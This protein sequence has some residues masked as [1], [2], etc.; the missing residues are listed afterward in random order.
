MN[1]SRDSAFS[2]LQS[3]IALGDLR[4]KGSSSTVV[5]IHKGGC[6]APT[7]LLFSSDGRKDNN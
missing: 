3:S 1:P 6:C 2:T 7:E 4:A 5:L